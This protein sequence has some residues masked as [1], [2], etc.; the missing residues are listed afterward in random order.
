MSEIAIVVPARLASQRF[1]RKPLFEIK[2]KPLLLWTAERI[3]AVAPDIPCYF[4]VE[5]SAVRNMLQAHGYKPIM[6]ASDHPSGTDRIAEAND[7]I[8][9]DFVINVQGDEP[10]VTASQIETLAGLIRG[11]VDMATLATHFKSEGDFHDPNKVKVVLDLEGRALYFSRSPIPFAREYKG[12]VDSA[13]L[14]DNPCFWHLGMYAYS[15]GFLEKFRELPQGHLES[16]ERLEQLRA[17]ENGFSIAVGFTE[18]RSMGID[19][20]GDAAVF[21]KLLEEA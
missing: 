10:M 20:P 6:T 11:P 19:T 16:I 2:G 8:G 7:E 14:Q 5:D 21:E 18:E 13:W 3:A 4:A 15:A 12:Y 17:L 1:P 9:A